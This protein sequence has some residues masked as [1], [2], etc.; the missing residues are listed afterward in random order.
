LR[1]EAS[2]NKND[3]CLIGGVAMVLTRLLREPTLVRSASVAA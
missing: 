2:A 1:V 3:A